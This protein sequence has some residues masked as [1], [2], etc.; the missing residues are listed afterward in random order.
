MLYTETISGLP[1]LWRLKQ[2]ALL[3]RFGKATALDVTSVASSSLC[4]RANTGVFLVLLNGS[5][6]I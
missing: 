3:R 5:N 2:T 4:T 6:S 1:F